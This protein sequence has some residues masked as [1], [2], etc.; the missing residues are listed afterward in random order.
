MRKVVIDGTYQMHRAMYSAGG[1]LKTANGRPSAGSFIFL[2]MLWNFK[3]RGDLIV[4]FDYPGARSEFRKSIYPEYKLRSRPQTDEEIQ[5]KKEHYYHLNFTFNTLREIL[6]M[7]GVPTVVVEDQE[8]DDVVYKLVDE[9]RSKLTDTEYEVVSD[10]KDYLQ[11]LN[12]DCNVYQPMKEKFWT[13]EKFEEEFQFPTS[14]FCLFKS[15][16]GDGSDNIPGVKGMGEKTTAKVMKELKEPT[17]LELFSWANSGNKS[18]HKKIRESFGLIKR[19][20]LLIDISHE[21]LSKEVVFQEYK[22]SLECVNIDPRGVMEKFK[23]LE[24]RSLGMWLS[25]LVA[26]EKNSV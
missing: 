16:I 1:G 24:F 20:L 17:I 13:K 12:L 19:N 21:P 23:S 4:V 26:K 3:E 15:I 25:Y 10:D 22:R 9:M 18:G 8:G 14:H 7:M 6:P 5:K 11:F 2:K